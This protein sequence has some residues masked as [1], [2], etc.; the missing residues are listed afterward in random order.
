MVGQQN[1]YVADTLELRDGNLFLAFYIW[2]AYWPHLANTTEPSVCGGNA[3][4]VKLL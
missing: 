4:L 3:A 1:A 2:G